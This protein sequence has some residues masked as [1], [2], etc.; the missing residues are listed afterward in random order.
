LD[1]KRSLAVIRP[2]LMDGRAIRQIRVP[3]GE[4]P[5]IKPTDLVAPFLAVE[6][7]AGLDSDQPRH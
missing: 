1:R 3:D 2:A 6:T 4:A 5:P 7:V